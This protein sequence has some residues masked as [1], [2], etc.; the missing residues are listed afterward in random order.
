M[1]ESKRRNNI[2]LTTLMIAMTAA[3]W[4]AKPANV[5]AD[6]LRCLLDLQ[7]YL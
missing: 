7:L 6:G 4:Q 1:I 5:H 3:A 2:K